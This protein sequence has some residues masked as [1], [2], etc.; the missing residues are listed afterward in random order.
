M[1]INTGKI[2]GTAKK[3]LFTIVCAL[4]AIGAI[5][6]TYW[7]LGGMVDALKGEADTRAS[8][9]GQLDG[10]VTQSR[11]LPLTDPSKTT[12]DDLTTFP[13]EKTLEKGKAATDDVSAQSQK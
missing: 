2:I 7:P 4:I 1:A 10:L 9:Y 3:N 12:P 11:K 8:L 5:V 6:A 13:N